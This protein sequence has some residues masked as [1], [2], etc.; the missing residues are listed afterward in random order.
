MRPDTLQIPK[1]TV[2][3][4]LQL[5]S[6]GKGILNKDSCPIV[7]ETKNQQIGSYEIKTFYFSVRKYHLNGAYTI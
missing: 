1:D 4:I 2:E 7:H 6:T 3:K 5:L